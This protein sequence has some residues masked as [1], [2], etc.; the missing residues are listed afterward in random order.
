MQETVTISLE[1]YKE[2]LVTKGKY[3][4]AKGKKSVNVFPTYPNGFFK[5]P[6]QIDTIPTNDT[7]ITWVKESE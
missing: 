3:E 7:N 5:Y 2:L 4:E 1:E 6:Y